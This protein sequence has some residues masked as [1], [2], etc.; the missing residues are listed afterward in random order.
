MKYLRTPQDGDCFNCKLRIGDHDTARMWA[1]IHQMS[2]KF[3]EL[4][5]VMSE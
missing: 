1:C 4:K 5:E 3:E 2:V